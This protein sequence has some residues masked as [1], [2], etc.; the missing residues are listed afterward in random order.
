MKVEEKALYTRCPTCSTAFKVTDELLALAN[1]KVRC[2]ACLAIFQATDYMLERS[3]KLSAASHT[4][5]K[6]M[7]ST[8]VPTRETSSNTAETKPIATSSL[9]PETNFTK[10]TTD[11]PEIAHTEIDE[12]SPNQPERDLK[13]RHDSTQGTVGFEIPER[14]ENSDSISSEDPEK[15]KIEPNQESILVEEFSEDLL[16]ENLLEN[17][18]TS[19]P[20]FTEQHE[21]ES[22]SDPVL[23]ED[24][25]E[26]EPE[27]SIF[28]EELD[29]LELDDAEL[30]ESE[31]KIDEAD[32][33]RLSTKEDLNEYEATPDEVYLEHDEH[34]IG[35][36]TEEL[37]DEYYE[38]QTEYEEQAAEDEEDP[39]NYDQEVIESDEFMHD[40]DTFDEL[41]DQLSEQMQDTDYEPDPLDE[42]EEMVSDNRS[43]IKSKLIA[44][45]LLILLI[46]GLSSV[47]NNRQSLAWSDTWGGTITSI[48]GYLPC[49]LKPKRDVSKIKLLQ[50]Q[51]VPDEDLENVLDV[52]VLL[53][54]EATFAQPYPT[55]KIAFSNKDDK[56]VLVKG[57]K[58]SD[59]LDAESVNDLM[60]PESEVHIHFKT[61]VAGSDLYGFQFIFE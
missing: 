31:L 34:H 13:T 21:I 18:P 15:A 10:Q 40:T 45:T 24:D 36:A 41:S 42:F 35:E 38:A 29:D 58:P 17:E 33:E 53:I 37:E 57:F 39:L 61:E 27:T 51:L 6:T 55:I 2:G 22:L 60:P 28:D 50:R 32:T 43:G 47:W 20:T 44:A 16:E 14:N 12:P 11:K 19:Q 46:I 56:Q 3:K 25:F 48:C 1:G 9:Q 52:K 54:N 5:L 8:P 4:P 7:A 49:D 30:E 23:S 26:H 59:Y